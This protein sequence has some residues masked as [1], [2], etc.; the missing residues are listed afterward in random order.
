MWKLDLKKKKR[1]EKN[2]M[3]VKQGK[4]LG[5]ATIGRVEGK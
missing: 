3:S 2:D 5:M 4:S 1:K